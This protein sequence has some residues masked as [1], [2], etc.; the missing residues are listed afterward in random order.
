MPLPHGCSPGPQERRHAHTTT[1]SRAAR[2]PLPLRRWRIGQE[3]PGASFQPLKLE[4]DCKRATS[5]VL[6]LEQ[7]YLFAHLQLSGPGYTPWT[8]AVGGVRVAAEAGADVS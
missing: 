5:R 7:G 6:A 1:L 8:G 2:L 4:L 3:Q